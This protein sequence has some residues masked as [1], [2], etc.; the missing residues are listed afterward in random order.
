MSHHV[1]EYDCQCKECEGTGLYVGM[2]EKDGFAVVCSRCKGT[3]KVHEKIEYD[4]FNG[5]KEKTGIKRVLLTN[6]GIGVGV[7]EMKKSGKKYPYF[8]GEE[9]FGGLSYEDWKSGKPFGKGTEM[10]DFT[11]PAWWYQG[12][13]YSKKPDWDECVGCGAFRDCVNFNRKKACWA[14]FD[15]E[16]PST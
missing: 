2:A 15:R 3:G 16:H 6:P 9:S 14:K 12:A 8:A 7:G 4:D 11:C 1:I 10:R 13:D 5:R